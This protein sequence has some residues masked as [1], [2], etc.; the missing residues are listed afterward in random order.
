[1]NKRKKA[2]VYI[3]IVIKAN[4]E[5]VW[6]PALIYMDPCRKLFSSLRLVF[7]DLHSSFLSMSKK[8]AERWNIRD[9]CKRFAKSFENS[10]HFAESSSRFHMVRREA[11][12]D[13]G[14]VERSREREKGVGG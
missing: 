11:G 14:K 1:V 2:V 12:R 4:R 13:R 8:S 5:G 9:C 6:I 7:R 10:H 3:A